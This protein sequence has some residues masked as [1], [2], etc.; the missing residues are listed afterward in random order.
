MPCKGICSRYKA[1]KIYKL[2]RYALGQKRCGECNLWTM[3]AG[4]FCPCCGR[5]MAT[6]PK[7]KKLLVVA[8][9]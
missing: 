2:S 6:K 9:Y 4:N 3:F 8:R 5:H 7:N 1:K